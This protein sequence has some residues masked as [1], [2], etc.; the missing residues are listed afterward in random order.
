MLVTANQRLA[1]FRLQQFEKA[2]IQAKKTAWQTP[3][4]QSW[5][6]WIKEQWLQAGAG[7][8]LSPQQE[9][10]FWHNAITQD[11]QTLVLNTKALAK[12]AMEAWQILADYFIDPTCLLSGGEEHIALYRWAEAVQHAIKQHNLSFVQQYTMLGKLQESLNATQTQTLILDGFD[13]LSPAQLSFLEHLQS[14]GCSIYQTYHEGK[15]SPPKLYIYQDE[16]SELRF[17]CQHIRNLMATDKN[18]TIGLLIPDLEQRSALVNQILSEELA[19]ALPLNSKTDQEG[20][21]FNLSMGSVLGKQPV[22]QAAMRLLS[23]TITPTLD[24]EAISNLLHTPY[25]QGYTQESSLRAELDKALRAANY[26]SLSLKQ[27]LY[28]AQHSDNKTPILIDVLQDLILDIAESN[29]FSGKQY[30]SAWLDKANHVL[31]KL[32]CFTTAESTFEMAQVQGWKDLITQLSS[33]DD[34]C[35]QVTWAEAL[36]YLQEYT[37][38]QHFRPAPSLANV[39]VMGFLEAS[40]LEFDEA[41]IISMDDQTWP[42]AARPHP[43]IPV[44]IQAQYQTPHANSEREWVYA[45]TVWQNVLCIAPHIHVSYAKIRD[46]HDVQASPLLAGLSRTELPP[47]TSQRYATQLQQQHINLEAI[48][49][50]VLPVGKDEHIHGGTNILAAQSACSFQ[51][52]AK[53]RLKLNSFEQPTQGLNAR[54]QGTLLHKVLELFWQRFPSQQKL[55]SLIDANTLEGEIKACIDDAWSSLKRFIPQDIQWLETRRLQRLVLDWL[56]LESNRTPF[57]VVEREAWRDIKLGDLVL[58][59][60]LDRID[61]DHEG[62]R[63]ILDYK[64]GNCATSSTLGERPESP[65]LPAYLLAEQDNGLNIDALAFAQVRFEGMGFKGFAKEDG[66]L[67]NIRGYKGRKNDPAD[68]DELTHHWKDTLNMLADEFMAGDISVNPKTAQSC[69]YCEF[70][71]LCR[72]QH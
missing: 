29:S 62:R 30:L 12:Q 34:F 69:T 67:P 38:E 63:M 15:T 19:P 49:D 66:I 57:K 71:G 18:K 45:Q 70:A 1:R 52:F 10:L 65:Q 44:D 23:L 53:Y 6:A 3:H 48:E 64:T 5:S 2:Q 16:E 60:K 46:Q 51:A 17:V 36:G 14:L 39:Q 25:L 37:Y 58:H 9:L 21:Y 33:L 72:I 35:G 7:L 32:Q 50:K 20:L 8:L 13:S 59:T 22:I 27:L 28:F 61:M 4:I 55:R 26:Q 68:W 42:P 54:E 47:F 31:E 24:S 43:L 41:F 56:M 11:E 40:N